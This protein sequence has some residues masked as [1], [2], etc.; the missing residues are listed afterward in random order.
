MFDDQSGDPP[1]V[2]T[3]EV[4][5]SAAGMDLIMQPR[6]SR[7]KIGSQTVLEVAWPND[8]CLYLRD[9]ALAWFG[10]G[11]TMYF[12]TIPTIAMLAKLQLIAVVSV[13]WIVKYRCKLQ[14]LYDALCQS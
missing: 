9:G 5:R 1:V 14:S 11:Y 2:L 4:F 6:F 10:V 3:Y 12:V 13:I 8:D 7:A